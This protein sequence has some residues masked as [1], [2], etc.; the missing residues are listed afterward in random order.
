MNSVL[1][2]FSFHLFVIELIGSV[3]KEKS[4]GPKI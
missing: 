2:G 1:S 3:H 4:A